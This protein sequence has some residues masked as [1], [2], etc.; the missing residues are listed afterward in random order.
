MTVNSNEEKMSQWELSKLCKLCKFH[1]EF[2]Q[3]YDSP[4]KQAQNTINLSD[5]LAWSS[6]LFSG[7]VVKMRKRE[8]GLKIYFIFYF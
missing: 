3:W 1:S 6:L 7:R 2:L 8:S 4:M 5:Y